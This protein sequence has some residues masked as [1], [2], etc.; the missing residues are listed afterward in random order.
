M[1]ALICAQAFP[2]LLKQAGGVAKDYLALCRALIDG[3]DW[4]VTLLSPVNI[5][6][7][8]EADVERWLKT[9]QLVHVPVWALQASNA[10]GVAVLMDF[11]SIHNT[12]RLVWELLH[13]GHALCFIDDSC[14]R[15]AP[16]MLM[17]GLG[18]PGIATTHSDVPSHPVYNQFI[19]LKI[20]W[21]LHLA[22][23]FFA[24]LHA[25]VAHVYAKSLWD[26]Y[27][28]PVD[29]V[30]PPVLWSDAFRRPL[31]DFQES[32][33]AKRACWIEELGFEPRAIFLFAGRWSAEKRI[34]L[35]HDAVPDDCGLI[36]VGDSDADYADQ[37]EATGRRN[38]L[39][40][41]GML[42][43][44][45]LRI[46]YAASDLFVSASTCETL[47]N[48][49][50]EAWS[51][52]IPVAIQPVGGHL[53]FVK[54]NEN[55]YFVDF[56]ASD[57]ARERLASIVARGT[58]ASVE[59]AL[60]KMGDYFRTLDFP[61]EVQRRLLE[62][63]LSTSASWQALTGWRW[64]MEKLVRVVLLLA[65]CFIWPVTVVWSRAYFAVSCDPIY[66]YVEPGTAKEPD[67]SDRS[68]GHGSASEDDNS[69]LALLSCV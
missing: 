10:L 60:S 52:G 32:A 2:P 59:P 19:L 65:C 38:I 57:E 42:G 67:A 62:P 36:I 54:D 63:A 7:S 20:L 51:A 49:V 34:H 31:H 40:K 14:M 6:E 37:I 11:F 25:S 22:S 56:D 45:D 43:A 5:G 66:R 16:L 64:M 55:S 3:L 9:G 28:I 33:A 58:K 15:I 26:R 35:L 69:R 24:T 27:R 12:C 61:A 29:G 44:E 48:T 46:V 21:W 4:Q 13:G 47:G 68:P 41:R 8:G 17:R 18:M 1:R 30:W 23:A 39:P 53:E 50:V